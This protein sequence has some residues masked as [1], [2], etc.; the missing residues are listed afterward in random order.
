MDRTLFQL[1]SVANQLV[2]CCLW[3][4]A[5]PT[6]YADQGDPLAIRTWPMGVVSLETHWNL[7]VA[8]SLRQAAVIP[9]ALSQADLL[10]TRVPDQ[11][12]QIRCELRTPG[13]GQAGETNQPNSNAERASSVSY[14]PLSELSLYLDRLENEALPTLLADEEA[15][16]VSKN[17]LSISHVEDRLLLISVD[18]VRVALP[19][20]EQFT[21]PE[22]PIPLDVLILSPLLPVSDGNLEAQIVEQALQSKPRT[23]VVSAPLSE[24]SKLAPALVHGNTVAVSHIPDNPDGETDPQPRSGP[25]W[26]QLRTEAWEMPQALAE[27]FQ[28]KEQACLHSQQIFAPLSVGQLNFKPSNGTHTARWNSE[29]MMGR[30]LLFFSQ[31]FAQQS[32]VIDVI[33][34]N[35]KQMPPEYEPRKAEWDGGEEA[36]QMERVSRFSRRFAYLLDGLELDQPAPGSSWTLRKLLVQMDKHYTEHTANVVKKFELADWPRE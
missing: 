36:R 3:I 25:Q 19:L 12:G 30:E 14:W 2:L 35:P 5:S 7:E 6:L 22:S 31:I 23:I 8:I 18:G 15:T 28:R 21:E 24:N 13:A 29:H 10:I 9:E 1:P 4:L 17:A 33:D 26:L 16:F 20:M 34:L 27:L 11:P 32:S